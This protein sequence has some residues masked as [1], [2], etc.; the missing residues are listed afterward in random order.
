VSEGSITPFTY[1]RLAQLYLDRG[2]FARASDFVRQGIRC[3][4][5]AKTDLFQ[6]IYFWFI[7]QRL[8]LRVKRR[9]R[10]SAGV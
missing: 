6:E 5:N 7:F 2:N 8:K 3:L 4:K 1:Q 10:Q 9:Q